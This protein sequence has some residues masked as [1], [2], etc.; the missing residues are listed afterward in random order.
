MRDGGVTGQAG[1]VEFGGK[2]TGFIV[3]LAGA[4]NEIETAFGWGLGLSREESEGEY[5]EAD[6]GKEDEKGQ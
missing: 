1:Q 6:F 2:V 5:S 4:V 3:D